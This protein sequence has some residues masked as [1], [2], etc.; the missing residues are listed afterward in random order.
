MIDRLLPENPD[1][2]EIVSR[3]GCCDCGA[4]VDHACRDASGAR[5]RPHAGRRATAEYRDRVLAHSIASQTFDQQ[6]GRS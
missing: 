2:V 1:D 3:A 6:E 4:R 5:C